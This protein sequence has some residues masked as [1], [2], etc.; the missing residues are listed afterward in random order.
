MAEGRK[1]PE[2]Q[3]SQAQLQIATVDIRNEEK[4]RSEVSEVVGLK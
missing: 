1:G 3:G 4:A 2:S